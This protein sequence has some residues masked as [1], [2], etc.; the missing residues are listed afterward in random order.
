MNLLVRKDNERFT[1]TGIRRCWFVRDIDQVFKE[2]KQNQDRLKHKRPRTFDFLNM[3]TGLNHAKIKKNVEAA[4]IEAKE[5]AAEL[6]SR[7]ER[8][9]Y[10]V[11]SGLN[12][13]A[14]LMDHV[15]FIVDNTFYHTKQGV[16]KHQK[17]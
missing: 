17:N 6:N 5:Y 3:Y 15:N 10:D 9:M 14:V 7:D 16:L 11:G 12:S 4:I 13:T 8:R 1:K 2:I